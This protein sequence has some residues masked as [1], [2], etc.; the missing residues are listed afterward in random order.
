M[1]GLG[2]KGQCDSHFA[3]NVIAIRRRPFRGGLTRGLRARKPGLLFLDVPACSQGKSLMHSGQ[4]P[5]NNHPTLPLPLKTTPFP[6]THRAGLLD[7]G[8]ILL[9]CWLL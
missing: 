5:L 3:L 1:V 2:R 7:G 6:N 8:G 4:R 9:A